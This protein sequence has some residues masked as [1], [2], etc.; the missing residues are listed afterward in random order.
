MGMIMKYLKIIFVT[1]ILFFGCKEDEIVINSTPASETIFVITSTVSGTDEDTTSKVTYQVMTSDFSQV[2]KFLL[3]GIEYNDW[4]FQPA[5]WY[6]LNNEYYVS[7]GLTSSRVV[8]PYKNS[9]SF[10]LSKGNLFTEGII[11]L[12]SKIKNFRCNGKSITSNNQN[13]PDTLQKSTIL[14][15]EWDCEVADS[16]YVEFIPIP[17]PNPYTGFSFFSSTRVYENV[18]F[19]PGLYSVRITAYTGNLTQRFTNP[20]FIGNYGKGISVNSWRFEYTILIIN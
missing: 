13:F 11:K 15:F 1:L 3:D 10:R 4:V 12:P 2:P 14:K 16:F 8:L 18:S 7:S 6:N 9:L 20:H 5:S 19:N 17:V